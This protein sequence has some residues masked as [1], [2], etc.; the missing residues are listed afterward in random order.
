[1]STAASRAALPATVTHAD[2]AFTAGRATLLGAAL[3]SASPELF[4]EALDDRLHEPYR[5]ESAPLLAAVREGLPS[6]A[7]GASLS[8]SGPTVIVWAREEAAEECAAALAESFPSERVVQ[9]QAA[10]SGAGR[11]P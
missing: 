1:M 2:A 4:A 9:L 8:G 7:L 5:A 3:A 11:V 10:A 6:E